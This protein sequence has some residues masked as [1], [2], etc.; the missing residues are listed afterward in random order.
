MGIAVRFVQVSSTFTR[1]EVQLLRAAISLFI[2]A[3]IA[4]VLGFSGMAGG[5]ASIAQLCFFVFIV[6]FLLSAV[7]SALSGRAPV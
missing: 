3:V 2:L 1:K 7:G 6:L 5:L 4:G